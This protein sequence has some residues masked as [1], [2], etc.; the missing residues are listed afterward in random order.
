MAPRP[1]FACWAFR[2][3]RLTTTLARPA[4]SEREAPVGAHR[5]WLTLRVTLLALVLGLLLATISALA[6]I[7][8]ASQ[9]RSLENLE[10]RYFALASETVAGQIQAALQPAA[11]SLNEAVYSAS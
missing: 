5:S 6:T 4:T 3:M 11:P 1:S 10:G 9:T 2:A 7:N 8:Y